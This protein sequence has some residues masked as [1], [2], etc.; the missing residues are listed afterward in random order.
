[1]KDANIDYIIELREQG[2]SY[3]EIGKRVNLGHGVVRQRLIDVKYESGIPNPSKVTTNKIFDIPRI[4]ELH[5]K[6]L[7]CNIIAKELNIDGKTVKKYLE[8]NG[9]KVDSG[10]YGTRPNIDIDVAIKMF[11]DGYNYAQIAEVFDT[12]GTTIKTYLAETGRVKKQFKLDQDA[13]IKLYNS[14]LN[15]EQ[16]A[17]TLNTSGG[18][19]KKYL[20]RNG[21]DLGVSKH[22]P[23]QLNLD[24]V[25]AVYEETRNIKEAAKRLGVTSN[26]IKNRLD[27]MKIPLFKK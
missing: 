4:I 10:K 22:A 21:F 18:V 15:L 17:K 23:I 11:D 8:L 26:T 13:I 19:V 5:N 27:Q 16:I 14:G 20:L 2:L 6:G 24:E 9:I 12:S 3:R 7:S 25:R 1:M